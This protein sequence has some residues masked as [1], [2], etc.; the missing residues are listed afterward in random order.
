MAERSGNGTRCVPYPAV[1]ATVVAG[2]HN[3]IIRAFRLRLEANR[4]NGMAIVCASMRKLVHIAFAI[5]KSGQPFDP[6]FSLP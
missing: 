1:Y 4:K 2:Q 3:P 5:L 6:H